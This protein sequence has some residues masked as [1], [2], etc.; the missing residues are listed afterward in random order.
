MTSAAPSESALPDAARAAP[1]QAPRASRRP[2]TPGPGAELDVLFAQRLRRGLA[3]TVLAGRTATVEFD[4]GHGDRWTVELAGGRAWARRGPAP[5]PTLRVQTTTGT[6][7]D[8][9]SGR[10]SG[11]DAFLDGRVV[12]RGHL[13]LALQL[14]GMFTSLVDRPAQHPRAHEAA[15]MGTRTSWIE[16]GE[17]DAPPVVLLHGLGATNASMLPILADLAR[18]HRVLAPDAPGFGSSDAPPSPYSSS[19]FAAWLEAFQTRTETR[20]AV[21]IGNSMGGRIA[22]EAGL[23]HPGAVRALILLAPSP[24]FR[25]LR[26]YVPFV[27]LLTP[28]LGRLP[29]LPLP[30]GLAVEGIRGMFS[31]PERLPKA[32]YDAAADEAVRVLRSPA[33]RVAMLSCARQ[34]YLEEAHGR[35]GFWDRLPGLEPPA[36]FLWGDRDRLVPASFARHV[37]DALPGAASIV[38]EDCGHVP[39]FE[40]P[41]ETMALIRGFLDTV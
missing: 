16:A 36:L 29:T 13:A 37:A 15:V 25:R 8:I 24:A 27:R 11:V 10:V 28:Q 35:R 30:H 9:V 2:R 32:W 31:V 5:A 22:L 6:L 40:H 39:H 21:L 20:G 23:Q 4:C 33:H 26:Q 41:E 14:D 3:G 7:A 18:D 34:I 17:P 19:W 1:P 12:V 38:L